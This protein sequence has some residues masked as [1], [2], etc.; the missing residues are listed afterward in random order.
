[1]KRLEWAAQALKL[2]E[3]EGAATLITQC[4]VEG[5]APR[6][7]G[8]KMLVSASS[9]I[10][11]IGGGN[12]EHQAIRQ[13]RA[14]LERA[15][16]PHLLQDYPLGPLLRQ[17]CGGHVRLLLERLD[18]NDTDWLTACADAET[19]SAPI[20]LVTRLDGQSPR[21]SVRRVAEGRAVAQP[22]FMS[23]DGDAFPVARPPREACGILVEPIEKRAP[24]IM[25]FGAGHVG[26]AIAHVL[27]I[28]DFNI[29]WF[30]SREDYTGEKSGIEI[31]SL[32][33]A[34]AA[35]S[36]GQPDAI[37]LILTHDHELDY[38]LTRAILL[39]SDFAYC[40]LIGSKT[41]RARFLK[42]LQGDGVP[43]D[44]IAR[45][46]SPIGLPE[47]DG[48]APAMIAVSVAAQLHQLAG[49]SA[50]AA[51]SISSVLRA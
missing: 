37:W 22:W 10:G 36:S 42:R 14:L 9:V 38:Q 4:I 13:A 17:C 47:L 12:L 45:L 33:D 41:K 26:E 32:D 23:T 35:V 43:E 27:S 48:K 19:T 5:S 40:G 46:T 11:T 29:R 44:A 21:K 24:T 1:M 39:R 51:S 15:D 18:E 34:D 3:A 28:A 16:L 2:I 30:D 50:A 25:L 49:A 8:T 31:E 6:E 20:E 7:A